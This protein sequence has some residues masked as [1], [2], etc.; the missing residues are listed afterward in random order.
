MTKT[1]RAIRLLPLL[2][3]LPLSFAIAQGA[4]KMSARQASQERLFHLGV[5][6]LQYSD[7]YD[8]HLPPM[9]DAQTTRKA[10]FG[11]A[12]DADFVQPETE[13]LYAPNPALS[14]KKHADLSNDIVAFYETV[15]AKDR[16]R[17]VLLLPPF[18]PK[19]VHYENNSGFVK[20][21]IKLLSPEQWRKIEPT[22]K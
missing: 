17:N 19:I 14:G 2:T 12:L 13:M 22:A 4:E 11:Y 7:D 18:D 3:F 5:A 6:L 16:S 8:G 9:T 15:P 21:Y 20:D 1:S 10:L